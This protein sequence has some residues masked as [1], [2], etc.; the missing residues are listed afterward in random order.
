[1]GIGQTVA[2]LGQQAQH[3]LR[4]QGAHL[5]RRAQIG[6]GHVIHDLVQHAALFTELMDGHHIRVVEAAG[7][8]AFAHEPGQG[9]GGH[10]RGP[11][12]DA[13][14]HLAADD[15]VPRQEHFA[16]AALSQR[17]DDLELADTVDTLAHEGLPRVLLP[18]RKLLGSA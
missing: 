5:Y 1:V 4:G 7:C 11:A 3:L 17:F 13:H 9:V 18:R 12:N 2:H 8:L 6:S 14:D 15:G 10:Q 16:Q